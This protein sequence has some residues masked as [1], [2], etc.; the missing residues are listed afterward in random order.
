[1]YDRL[2]A[3]NGGK[4]KISLKKKTRIVLERQPAGIEWEN[5]NV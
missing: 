1:M 4:S 3:G 5:K 2:K